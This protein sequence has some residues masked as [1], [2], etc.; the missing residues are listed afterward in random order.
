MA[1]FPAPASR[2]GSFARLRLTSVSGNTFKA[3][4]VAG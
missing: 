3:E 4:E 2:V 1:V